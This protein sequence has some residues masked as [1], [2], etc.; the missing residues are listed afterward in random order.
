MS[1]SFGM[2]VFFWSGED[3]LSCIK[4]YSVMRGGVNPALQVL[5]PPNRKRLG[6]SIKSIGARNDRI[7]CIKKRVGFE[8]ECHCLIKK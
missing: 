1:F 3:F 7:K 8:Q 4:R 2:P 6:G 5:R